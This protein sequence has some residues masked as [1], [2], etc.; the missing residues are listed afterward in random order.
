MLIILWRMAGRWSGAGGLHQQLQQCMHGP[1]WPAA[2]LAVLKY[3]YTS[4][5]LQGCVS[6]SVS[7]SQ[8]SHHFNASQHS[9]LRRASF[10][11]IL[12]FFASMR[13]CVHS[14]AYMR[15]SCSAALGRSCL[16]LSSCS[17][18]AAK[19]ATSTPMHAYMSHTY[20]SSKTSSIS[21]VRVIRFSESGPPFSTHLSTVVTPASYRQ[22]SW[23]TTPTR[24]LTMTNSL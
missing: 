4:A 15:P 19:A 9:Q 8:A 11:S 2:G 20:T 12:C 14:I 21:S 24:F 18:G 6:Q 23:S 22:A 17:S 7:V 5:A 1:G 10:C 3:T 13:A 16:H